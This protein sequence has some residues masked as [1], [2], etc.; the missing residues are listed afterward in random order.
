[1]NLVQKSNRKTVT[2]DH[3]KQE[4]KHGGL[5]CK[6]MDCRA[7]AHSSVNGEGLCREHYKV[8]TDGVEPKPY[9]LVLPEDHGLVTDYVLTTLEQML[10]C[11]YGSGE[12]KIRDSAPGFPGVMCKHCMGKNGKRGRYFAS[13]EQAMYYATFTK[14]IA[15]HLL[16]CAYCP[17]EVR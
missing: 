10:P 2:L 15:G 6:Y 14:S 7:M 3:Y 5:F 16:D 8:V 13:S 1:M 4:G 11:N 17:D 9:P 12:K